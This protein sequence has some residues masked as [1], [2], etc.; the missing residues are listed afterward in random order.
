MIVDL[1]YDSVTV[2]VLD[3]VRDVTVPVV[4]GLRVQRSALR[5]RTQQSSAI[6]AKFDFTGTRTFRLS[7]VQQR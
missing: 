1:S 7:A 3:S 6:K 4:K 2:V 5:Q